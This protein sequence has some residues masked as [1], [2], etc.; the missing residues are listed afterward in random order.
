VEELEPVIPVRLL[1]ALCMT[2]EDPED[3]VDAPVT[4]NP[5]EDEGSRTESGGNEKLS[6]TAGSILL[7]VS[8]DEIPTEVD[9]LVVASVIDVGERLSVEP[10]MRPRLE[11]EVSKGGDE[12][13][14]GN[15]VKLDQ[16]RRLIWLVGLV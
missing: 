11:P 1:G 6:D 12:K 2:F 16:V 14:E 13:L 8:V 10:V 5:V 15:A 4:H 3:R 9:G 7:D